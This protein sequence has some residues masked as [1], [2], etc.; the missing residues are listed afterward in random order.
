MTI[1][2]GQ[3]C[4]RISSFLPSGKAHI[5]RKMVKIVNGF[6]ENLVPARGIRRNE[7]SSHIGSSS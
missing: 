1:L 7:I 3:K 4:E 6:C 5:L 2:F